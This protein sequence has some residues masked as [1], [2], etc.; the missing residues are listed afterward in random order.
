M[1]DALTLDHVSKRFGSHQAVDAI[2]LRIPAGSIYGFLGQNGAGKTTTIRMIMSIYYPDSGQITVLGE[3]NS[4]SIK[5][6]LGYL[7]EEK[8]L[9][10]KMKAWELLAYFGTLKGVPKADAKVKA[11]QLLETVG[12]GEFSD[13]R[14]E[15]LS[16]GMGQKVQILAT[17]MHDPELVILD[18][19]F[20]GLD[21]VNV[22]MMREVILKMKRDGRTVIFSTHV[23]EN[24]EKLCDGIVMIHRGQKVLD[25]T[26]AEVKTGGDRGIQIDYDGDSSILRE[27]PGITRINDSGKHAEIFLATGTDPQEILKRLVGRLVI[28]RF[29]LREPSLH[30]VFFRAV[31]G[32][33]HE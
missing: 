18:E 22:E 32:E 3:P 29:D 28:R 8:G 31:K 7:P 21:P 17:I 15:Q 27:L 26:L 33:S 6:R 5:D 11:R 2:S 23:M 10:K 9:Y 4:E 16:K 12:L 1:T 13:H 19:P 30:E 24:A 20:S 14:C 25:G